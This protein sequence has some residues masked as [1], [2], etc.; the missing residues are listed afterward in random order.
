M[1]S[2]Q[3]FPEMFRLDGKVALVTGAARGLG[4]AMAEGLSEAGAE[5]VLADVL[6]EEG[7]ARARSLTA[8]GGKAHFRAMN[9]ADRDAVFAVMEEVAGSLGGID[10]LINNAGAGG[11]SHGGPYPAQE[12]TPEHWRA[13]MSINLD[14]PFYCCQAVH[15]IMRSRGGGAIV[16]I[17]S[18]W[19]LG[20]SSSM[21]VAAYASSKAALVNLTRQLAVE[22]AGDGIRVNAIAPGFFKTQFAAGGGG[23]EEADWKIKMRDQIAERMPLQ[24]R[25]EPDEIKGAAIFL[26]SDASCLVTGHTLTVDG[27]WMAW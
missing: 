5:V 17:A 18:V 19:G 8:S 27:G 10:I 6:S 23:G 9:V 26:A 11:K 24:R 13:L 2:Q 3:S 1:A 20:A 22:W 25:G 15:P 14:G 21:P 4:L 7:L 12:M 16:N